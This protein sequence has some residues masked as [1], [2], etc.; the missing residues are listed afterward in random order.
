M[1]LSTLLAESLCR[2]K[3]HNSHAHCSKGMADLSVWVR[4]TDLVPEVQRLNQKPR[5]LDLILR[6]RPLESNYQIKFTWCRRHRIFHGRVAGLS[7]YSH[8]SSTPLRE[9]L[10]LKDLTPGFLSCS[11]TICISC[12][13]YGFTPARVSSDAQ[14]D[15]FE[16][17]IC[18][19]QA[20]CCFLLGIS[21]FY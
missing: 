8:S 18:Q 12:Q 15:L 5:E 9:H 3:K 7:L 2:T 16:L 4:V 10:D 14:Q 20:K 19:D 11:N 17:L 1:K 6:E 13:V 21:T